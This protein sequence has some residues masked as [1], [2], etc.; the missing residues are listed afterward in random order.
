MNIDFGRL[1]SIVARVLVLMVCIPAHECAHG[2]VAYRLGD[3]TAKMQKRLTLNPLRHFDLL[4]TLALVLLGFGWAKPVPVNPANLRCGPKKGMALTALAGPVANILMALVLLLLYRLFLIALGLA[5]ALDS[6]AAAFVASI[7]WSMVVTNISLGVFNLLPINPLDGSRILGLLLPDRIYYALMRAERFM[8]VGLM[9]LL[10]FTDVLSK[11]LYWATNAI[12][13]FLVFITS[14]M[15][16][17]AQGLGL[18]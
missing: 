10:Y 6:V 16:L 2:W 9:L 8:M 17:L 7:L 13:R 11:P 14:F 1:Y 5:G 12:L 4:G 3:N 15:D 18:I